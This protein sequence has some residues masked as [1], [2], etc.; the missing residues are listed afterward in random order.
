MWLVLNKYANPLMGNRQTEMQT[1]KE[2]NGRTYKYNTLY[3][4]DKV[5]LTLKPCYWMFPIF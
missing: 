2:T 5:D 3:Y 1:D 4:T